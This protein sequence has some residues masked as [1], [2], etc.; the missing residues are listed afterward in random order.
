MLSC[1]VYV[2]HNRIHDDSRLIKVNFVSASCSRHVYSVQTED[3]EESRGATPRPITVF[4]GNR[5]TGK[6]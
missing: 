3:V 6:D 1:R 5:F 2:L 4:P